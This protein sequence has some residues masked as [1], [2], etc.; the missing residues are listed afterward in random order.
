MTY[1]LHRV[2]CATPGGLEPE[3]QAFHEV[4]GQ[5]NET[6]GMPQSILLVPVSIVPNMVN[7]LAFQP[8]VEANVQ[9]C[10][11]FVQVLHTT[12]GPSAR[13]FESEYNLAC[14]LKTDL[15][16]PMEDISLFFKA[17]SFRL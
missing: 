8:L 7:K 3:R 5:V 4:V 6:E 12:W 9:A 13:N 2:F 15:A 1:T 17:S 11:F 14:R 16:S 10:K